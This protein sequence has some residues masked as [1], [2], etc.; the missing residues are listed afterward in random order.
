MTWGQIADV[1]AG[2]LFVG[3]CFLSFAAGIGVLRFPDLLARIHAGAKP[4]V[5]GVLLALAGL[6]LRLRSWSAAA[7]LLLIAMFQML[8]APVSAHLLARAAYRTGKFDSERL[9]IDELTADRIALDE[10]KPTD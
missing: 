1:I 9:V 5:L 10:R 2:A 3:G 8:T 4:Q 6:A 7:T